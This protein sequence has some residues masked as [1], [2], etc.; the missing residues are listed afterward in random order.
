MTTMEENALL[1]RV[2]IELEEDWYFAKSKDLPGLVLV[3]QDESELMEDL[4][5]AIKLLIDVRYGVDCRVLP[6]KFGMEK[7][8]ANRPWLVAPA[9]IGSI[10][11]PMATA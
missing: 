7:S 9:G 6:T 10:S 2:D 8:K 3:D 1:I 4:P 11:K 5:R